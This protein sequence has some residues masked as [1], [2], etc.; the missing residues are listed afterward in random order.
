MRYVTYWLDRPEGSVYVA[1]TVAENKFNQWPEIFDKV[2]MLMDLVEVGRMERRMVDP[3]AD[4]MQKGLDRDGRVALYGIQFDFNKA[5]IKPD[6]AGTL[7]EIGQLMQSNRALKLYVV[8]HTDSVGGV[9]YNK[10]L[11]EKRA[12][13]VVQWLVAKHAVAGDRL[14]PAGVGPLAPVATNSTE[15]GRAKNRRVELVVRP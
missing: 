1:L 13:A 6:S 8:G 3:K 10:D 14:V 9:A 2:M 4:E 5:E 15:E 7:A 12:Q 11:S